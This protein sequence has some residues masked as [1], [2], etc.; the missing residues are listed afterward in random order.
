[1]FYLGP[2]WHISSSKFHLQIW[3]LYTK[4]KNLDTLFFVLN[5]KKMNPTIQVYPQLHKF[6]ELEIPST[7]SST[8]FLE[9]GSAK[10]GLSV[11]DC[12]ISPAYLSYSQSVACLYNSFPV[13]PHLFCILLLDIFSQFHFFFPLK[14]C[15]DVAS[16][17]FKSCFVLYLFLILWMLQMLYLQYSFSRVLNC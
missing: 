1:M 13:I 8:D 10:Q 9:L 11:F 15:F 12:E 2:I 17:C 7:K 16:T 6:V 3:S 5:R 14:F 4:I